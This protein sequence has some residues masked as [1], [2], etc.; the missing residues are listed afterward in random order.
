MLGQ[1]TRYSQQGAGAWNNAERWLQPL[2]RQGEVAGWVRP[3]RPM[4]RHV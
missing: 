4:S 1:Q 2:T 3:G